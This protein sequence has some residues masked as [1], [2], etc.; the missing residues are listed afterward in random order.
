[1]RRRAIQPLRLAKQTNQL[2]QEPGDS[3]ERCVPVQKASDPAEQVPEQI[4]WAR[5]RGD[6]QDDPIAV[7][8]VSTIFKPL[9][10][11]LLVVAGPV[12]FGRSGSFTSEVGLRVGRGRL[13]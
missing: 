3:R 9:F 11:S 8:G 5:L 13:A 7:R 1:V 4:A 12:G 6:V 10:F 2:A